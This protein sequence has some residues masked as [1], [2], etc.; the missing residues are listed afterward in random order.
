MRFKENKLELSLM[1]IGM[2]IITISHF[3]EIKY[4]K[5]YT[6]CNEHILKIK[7][8]LK[9]K[10][11]LFKIESQKKFSVSKDFQGG[12]SIPYNHTVSSPPPSNDNKIFH[13]KHISDIN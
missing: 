9:K 11:K 10:H 6:D 7:Y 12:Y 3:L 2:G 4:L 8:K 13:L 5:S 1:Y